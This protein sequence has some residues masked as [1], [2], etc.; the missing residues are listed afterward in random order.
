[1]LIFFVISALNRKIILLSG[2]PEDQLKLL[3]RNSVLAVGI[4]KR[5][6][7]QRKNETAALQIA[8]GFYRDGSSMRLDN[9]LHQRHTNTSTVD[10]RI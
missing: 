6:S 10:F 5:F 4:I 1:M 7:R 3:N 8:I 9:P 2:Q